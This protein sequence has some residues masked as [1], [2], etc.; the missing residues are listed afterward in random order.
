[1]TIHKAA[2]PAFDNVLTLPKHAKL[3]D[4]QLQQGIPQLW[5]LFSEG[6][7]NVERQ[8]L[9]LD[10]EERTDCETLAYIATIQRGNFVTHFF[11]NLAFKPVSLKLEGIL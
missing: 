3:L 10:T 4:V 7:E 2:L 5:Y 8:I 6:Y 1:M 9:G 11:E